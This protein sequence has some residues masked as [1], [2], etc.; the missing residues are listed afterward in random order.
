M[1]DLSRIALNRSGSTCMQ[2]TLPALDGATSS[3]AS[4]DTEAAN[5]FAAS[6]IK[7]VSRHYYVTVPA[8]SLAGSGNRCYQLPI[9]CGSTLL[10]D[11]FAQHGS[12]VINNHQYSLD[13]QSP[14]EEVFEA[15]S[16]QVAGE[17]HQQAAHQRGCSRC[18]L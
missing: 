7:S 5:S 11:T 9:A 8:V 6:Q 1:W 4:C 17:I 13:L 16:F 12:I 14:P 3:K 2:Q 18:S 10:K 15:K